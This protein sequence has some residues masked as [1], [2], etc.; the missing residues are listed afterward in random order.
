MNNLRLESQI[1]ILSN[2]E[3]EL[4]MVENFYQFNFHKVKRN[5]KLVS[6]IKILSNKR[7][8]LLMVED[9]CLLNF[10]NKNHNP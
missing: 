9:F 6:Q 4:P 10:R 2:K 5:S 3:L 7:L 8:E 1:K